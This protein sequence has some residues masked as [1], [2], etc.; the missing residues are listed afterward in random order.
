M[1]YKT[2]YFHAQCDGG[3]NDGRRL[4]DSVVVKKLEGPFCGKCHVVSAFNIIIQLISEKWF[5]H[6]KDKIHPIEKQTLRTFR[7]EIFPTS[8]LA[9]GIKLKPWMNEIIIT[10][11]RENNPNRSFTEDDY[12]FSVNSKFEEDEF[13]YIPNWRL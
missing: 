10:Q 9:C 7:D 1:K 4:S 11:P 2:P 12:E 5:I 3:H 6:M 8:R 13:K